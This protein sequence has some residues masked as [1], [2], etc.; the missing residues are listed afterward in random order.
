MRE[1]PP[2]APHRR[3]ARQRTQHLLTTLAALPRGNQLAERR[4]AEEALALARQAGD[5]LLVAE[6]LLVRCRHFN[7]LIQPESA[8]AGMREAARIFRAN[9][10]PAREAAC[11]LVAARALYQLAHERQAAAM[12]HAAL[13]EPALPAADRVSAYLLLFKA[14]GRMGQLE[15]AFA[16]LDGQALPLARNLADPWLLSLSLQLKGWLFARLANSLQNAALPLPAHRVL[17]PQ[18]SATDGLARALALLDQA[19]ACLPPGPGQLAVEMDRQYAL[20]LHRTGAAAAQAP[21]RLAEL[22]E[23]LVGIDPPA[24]ADA[25]FSRALLLQDAGQMDL[26][27]QALPP[28]LALSRQHGLHSQ[29]RDVMY[30]RA[31][32]CEAT[33]DFQAAYAALKEHSR[34]CLS[35][36]GSTA[37]VQ[38][39]WPESA[40]NDLG[41]DD[42]SGDDRAG[43]ALPPQR[44]RELEP[45]HLKRAQRWIG[46]RIGQPIA[47]ADVVRACGVSRRTL[48]AAFRAG[49]GTTVAAYI[50]RRQIEHAAEQLLHTDRPVREIALSIGYSSP[51]MFAREFRDRLGLTPT[52][53]RGMHRGSRSTPE[54]GPEPQ[55]GPKGLPDSA[56][57]PQV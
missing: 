43:A 40:G 26:A 6:C 3:T 42:G 31:L 51:T 41:K 52:Q 7:A 18:G 22:A 32:I 1:L 14:Y 34:M 45:A 17:E 46:Q 27:L 11:Q 8:W 57:H 33:G 21:G 37:D 12:A 47:V 39:V 24:A 30:L 15:E 38:A 48:D 10:L 55:G 56:K 28:A 23:Q 25:H 44:V 19:Q 20:G 13:Q 9:G 2:T 29:T 5:P 53:W 50:R 16:F 36:G 49:K 35:S 54:P 4:L